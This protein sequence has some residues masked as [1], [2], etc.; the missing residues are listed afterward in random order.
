ML[1]LEK[2]T[3]FQKISRSDYIFIYCIRTIVTISL[4]LD[5]NQHTI[6]QF[7]IIPLSIKNTVSFLQAHEMLILFTQNEKQKIRFRLFSCTSDEERDASIIN[8]PMNSEK[9]QRAS[10]PMIYT[11]ISSC[12]RASSCLEYLEEL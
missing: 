2:M 7:E 6:S 4:I 5:S 10:E 11:Y 9:I 12:K 1:G 3:L 8:F